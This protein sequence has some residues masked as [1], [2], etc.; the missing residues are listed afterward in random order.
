ML[1]INLLQI[2]RAANAISQP[3][4]T[5]TV[6]GKF[7]NSEFSIN[8]WNTK[9]TIDITATEAKPNFLPNFSVL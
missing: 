5:N 9:K 8:V 2:K 4:I 3:L 7:S 6:A 1:T